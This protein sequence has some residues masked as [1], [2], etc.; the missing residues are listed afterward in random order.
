MYGAGEERSGKAGSGEAAELMNRE[1]AEQFREFLTQMIGQAIEENNEKLSQDISR[2]VNDKVLKEIDYL[3]RWQMSGTKSGSG[4][5]MRR[6]G[7]I[8]RRI[9]GG[10]KLRR[11][12]R[13][14]CR[15][16]S[17]RESLEKWE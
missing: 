12:K 11:R 8:R 6:S 16:S 9:K 4:S 13:R 1:K 17:E 14:F 3:M 15:R 2:M 7:F 5:W 10:R